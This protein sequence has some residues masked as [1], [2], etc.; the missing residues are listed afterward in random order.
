MHSRT[1]SGMHLFYKQMD[2]QTFDLESI[3]KGAYPNLRR[4]SLLIVIMSTVEKRLTT[5]CGTL[6]EK[7][8]CSLNLWDINDRSL[9]NKIMILFSKLLSLISH[10]FRLHF[11][12]SL[13]VPH[14]VVSLFS[15]VLIITINKLCLRRLG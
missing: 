8:K 1:S 2:G 7:E 15:T 10:K 11:S 13:N 14:K 5:L 9:L 3:I 6:R 12:F 4:Q